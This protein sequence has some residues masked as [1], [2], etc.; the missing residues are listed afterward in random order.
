MGVD[1][2]TKNIG[3]A[4]MQTGIDVVLPFGIIDS[5]AGA[6]RSAQQLAQLVIKEKIDKIVFGL[7]LGTDGRENENTE[8][9]RKFSG[10]LENKIKGVQIEFF[11]ELFS[12]KQADR[13]EGG[14]SRDE[15]AAMVFLEGYKSKN[16][17]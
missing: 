7:P 9:V 11:N 4:W 17:R 14:A 10:L 8:K 12:S 15:K 2:G 6:E 13:M 3:L 5:S 16:K 1:Y